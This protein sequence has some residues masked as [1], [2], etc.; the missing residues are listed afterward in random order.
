M[1][2]LKKEFAEKEVAFKEKYAEA[3]KNIAELQG[4]DLG[5]GYDM[6]K[7]IPR[8]GDYKCEVELD[9]E[10]LFEDYAELYE[11]SKKINQGE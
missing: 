3:I 2:E 8:G 9:K 5:V 1:E 7:A 6:L 4:V 10:E 11:L